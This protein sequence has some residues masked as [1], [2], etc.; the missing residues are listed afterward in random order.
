[1]ISIINIGMNHES[2][3]VE[4]RECLAGD[5]MSPA[6]ILTKMR[7]T[8]QLY[9]SIFISTCN[10]IEALCTTEDSDSA[11][12]LIVTLVS[13]SSGVSEEEIRS[14]MYL[15]K[16]MDAVKHM[17]RVAS[18]LD[19]MV[20]GEP[21]ILGQVKDAYRL[22][23]VKEKTAGVIINRLMHKTFQVAKRVRT[24]TG[25]SETAVS[26]SYAAVE[27]A[28]KIFYRLEGRTALLVG[29]GEMAELAAK[30]LINHGVNDLVVA[31]RSFERAVELAGNISGKAVF[32]KELDSQ[33]INADIVISSTAA[34]DYIITADMIRKIARK[35]KNR[36]LFLID[37][38]VPRDIE[39]RV[40][41][42]D[43]VFLYDI[44]DLKEVVNENSEQRMQEAIVAERIIEEEVMKFVSWLETLD[45]VPTIVLLK[46]KI[47][48]I[49]AAEIKKSLPGLGE[50]TQEQIR[51]IEILTSSMAE[52]I[53]NDPI[54]SLKKI[55]GRSS[56]DS[57]IDI[58]RKLFNLD[59]DKK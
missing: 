23:A 53:I 37:I 13:Q 5:R 28:K 34:T 21:Q 43:N 30:H 12:K 47:E 1:M 49:R 25:I 27:L 36:P 55:A 33:L 42:L 3:P 38:A 8:G 56:K 57:Y 6:E 48:A 50:L 18:S 4:L 9:E 15:H 41:N 44:D 58:T 52:K 39:P 14:H 51:N 24:E 59:Q 45:V 10:R 7:E 29:A 46:D 16:D 2:A 32:F 22:A 19:S 17:F 40:N 20:V 31:N 26:I 35:R 54:I 11:E